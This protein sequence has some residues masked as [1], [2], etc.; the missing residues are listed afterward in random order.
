MFAIPTITVIPE[1][2]P[3]F[4]LPLLI[5][6]IATAL[7]VNKYFV[8]R[9]SQSL[10]VGAKLQS[11]PNSQPLQ[12]SQKNFRFY[13]PFR[14][15]V[16]IKPRTSSN[17]EEIQLL[18]RRSV[19]TGPE[20]SHPY[21]QIAWLGAST[22]DNPL[23]MQQLPSPI[24][25]PAIPAPYPAELEASPL[26]QFIS[27]SLIPTVRTNLQG[28]FTVEELQNRNSSIINVLDDMER[29]IVPQ[30]FNRS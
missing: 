6:T 17:D 5:L 4:A 11:S 13:W 2:Y 25:S 20:A 23:N 1:L 21:S 18:N 16:H 27:H 8:A 29:L 9:E 3:A 22:Q 24:I 26:R 12:P 10:D 30:L 15:A 19:I 7:V 28:Q 14:Q